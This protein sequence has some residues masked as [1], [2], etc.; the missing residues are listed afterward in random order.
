MRKIPL[1]RRRVETGQILTGIL[2]M[3]IEVIVAAR[4]D[5]FEFLKAERKLVL[6]VPRRLRVKNQVLVLV[7][8]E[9]LFFKSEIEIVLPAFRPPLLIYFHLGRRL[10]KKMH[11][12]PF[13]FAFAENI[14]A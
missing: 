12:H 1:V 5:S 9:M 11:L 7:P 6:D 8:F 2:L 13:E 3:L 14:L 4:M 10:Y